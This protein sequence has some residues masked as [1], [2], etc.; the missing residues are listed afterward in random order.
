M[1]PAGDVDRAQELVFNSRG[2]QRAR[3]LAAQH[4][5]Q[6]VQAVSPGRLAPHA[7]GPAL[8]YG[9]TPPS[10]A[11]RDPLCHSV[12]SWGCAAVI[13]GVPRSLHLP[14]NTI[15]ILPSFTSI[16]TFLLLLA[17]VPNTEMPCFELSEVLSVQDL[18]TTRQ[19]PLKR[20]F[21]DPLILCSVACRC[22]AC[23]HAQM[24]MP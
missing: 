16:A 5:E 3:D 22:R 8:A 24:S 10:Q 18:F 2:I 14:K 6:A 12:R 7:L 23:L 19:L 4:A 11:H 1:V 21:L 9:M 13:V 20:H 17:Q 15:Y